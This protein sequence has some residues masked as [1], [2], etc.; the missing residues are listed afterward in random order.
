M[1]EKEIELFQQ[2]KSSKI[3]SSTT[4]MLENIRELQ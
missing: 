1:S 2:P 3:I 4:N